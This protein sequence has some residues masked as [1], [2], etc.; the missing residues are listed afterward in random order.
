MPTTG[1]PNRD[2]NV[3]ALDN[4]ETTSSEL[5]AAHLPRSTGGEGVQHH[6]LRDPASGGDTAKSRDDRLA[7]FVAGDNG[8][9]NSI[10][11]ELIEELGFT[12]VHTGGLAEGGRRQQP[13][14]PVYAAN[15]TAA[16]ACQA[17]A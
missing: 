4:D 15:M 14:G 9:A 2:G 12:A 3:A 10:V 5:L 7:I 13:G 11:S 6:A 17:L 16:Q 8:Q 1:Y